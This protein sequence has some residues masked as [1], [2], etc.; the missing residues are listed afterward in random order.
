[1]PDPELLPAD[2]FISLA[3]RLPA[4]KGIVRMRIEIEANEPSSSP[5]HSHSH[6]AG[7]ESV[8]EVKAT[9][10]QLAT[11]PGLGGFFEVVV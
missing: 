10:A 8:R 11:D 4:Y 7:R 3:Q 1:V 5:S 2:R 6:S 9:S